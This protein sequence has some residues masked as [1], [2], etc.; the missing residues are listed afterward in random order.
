M[1]ARGDIERGSIAKLRKEAKAAANHGQRCL[2]LLANALCPV[3]SMD[4]FLPK[5]TPAE[6]DDESA[7]ERKPLLVMCCD[8]ERKQLLASIAFFSNV[9]GIFQKSKSA[10]TPS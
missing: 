4:S 6:E 9:Y 8:E 10:S 5:S 3:V 2:Q 7:L 1:E